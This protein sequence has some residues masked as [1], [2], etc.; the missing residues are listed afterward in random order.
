[1]KKING[2]VK[3]FC[4][5]N[6]T[7]YNNDGKYNVNVCNFDELFQLGFDESDK[8]KLDNMEVDD[9]SYTDF[10]GCYVIRIA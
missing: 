10:V 4:L 7:N 6:T 9:L 3:M 5:I 1:M 2:N 8:K